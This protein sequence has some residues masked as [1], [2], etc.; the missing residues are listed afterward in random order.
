MGVGTTP[1]N[2]TTSTGVVRNSVAPAPSCP[3][4]SIPQHLRPPA[5]VRAQ[6][7]LPP[8]GDGGHVA[9][10]PDRVEG[11]GGARGCPVAQ[12][13]ARVAPPA[14]DAAR[15]GQGAGVALVTCPQD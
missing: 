6:V 7:W 3:E 1:A 9:G 13:T 15:A 8:R 14:L 10:E 12:L 11:I 4:E 2:P 5:V